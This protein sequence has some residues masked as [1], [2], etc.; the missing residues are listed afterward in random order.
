MEPRPYR[1]LYDVGLCARDCAQGL[2][3]MAS[4]TYEGFLSVAVDA[5]HAAGLV[6][7]AAWQR[8][9]TVEHKGDVD[10]V[11]E[12]DK[13]CEQLICSRLSQAFPDHRWL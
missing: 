3:E 9:K 13:Q 2:C 11:T 5:A 7:S 1:V 8:T 10:L 4:S 12:T 6:I